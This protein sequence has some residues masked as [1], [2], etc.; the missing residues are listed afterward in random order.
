[1]NFT[2]IQK[3]PQKAK[4][5][6]TRFEFYE[7]IKAAT[8]VLFACLNIFQVVNMSNTVTGFNKVLLLFLPFIMP[9]LRTVFSPHANFWE[10]IIY[11]K[12]YKSKIII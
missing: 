8:E 6:K 5:S 11:P 1:M 3:N 10:L 2:T 7:V 9:Y 12:M 4:H